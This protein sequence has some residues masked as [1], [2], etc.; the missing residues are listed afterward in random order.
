MVLEQ[1]NQQQKEQLTTW[2]YIAFSGNKISFIFFWYH[3]YLMLK[4]WHSSLLEF[5]VRKHGLKLQF[6]DFATLLQL[7]L[8]NRVK[9]HWV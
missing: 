2:I 1:L 4:H 9:R 5:N 8:E 3:F 7:D 6:N